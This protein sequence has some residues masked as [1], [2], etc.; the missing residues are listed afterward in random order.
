MKRLK[1]LVPV[2]IAGAFAVSARAE[3]LDG[4]A[5]VVN[6]D[7]VLE[8]DVEEQLGLVLARSQ[9]TPDSDTVDT[10]R[11]QILNQ[12]IDEKLI[13]AEGK[14]QGL[15]ATD[16]EVAKE[17]ETAMKEIKQ[18]F[19]GDDGFRQQLIKENTTE[20]KL[21]EKFRAEIQRQIIGRK[22]MAKTL[23]KKTISQVEAEAYFKINHE[24]FPKVPAEIKLR[25]IQIPPSADS[26]TDARARVQ[27]LAIRKRLS[28]GEKFAKVAAEASDDPATARNGG[29]LGFVNR[30]LLDTPLEA[31]VFGL[32]NNEISGPVRSSAGW[33]IVQALERDTVKSVAGKDS[34]DDHGNPPVEVHARH[35]LVRVQLTEADADRAKK[36]AERVHTQA[37]KGIDFA[38][39]VKRYSK[40]DGPAKDG[41]LGFISVATLQPQI[42]AGLDSVKIGNVSDVLVNAAGFN[43]FKIVDR[44]GEREYE[45]SEIKEE[46]PDAVA[47]L[48]QRERYDGWIKTLRDR[49]HI[50]IRKS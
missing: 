3:R 16:A 35:I 47:E 42:R 18:R 40:Y 12:L 36:L 21:R 46:L 10:L 38:E 25:V 33:H 19:G 28:N 6:D 29:D 11:T 27:A 8:S 39:L 24:K 20:D 41:D 22:L 26:V 45:M 48:Q 7:V 4:I 49:A 13:F 9:A 31:V 32:K 17:L 2:L 43:I 14:K 37:V 1:W 5:A 30:G 15:T 50:E 44:K 23:P 34:L